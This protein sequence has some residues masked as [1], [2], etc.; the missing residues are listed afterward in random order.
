MRKCLLIL[1]LFFLIS[2]T[3]NKKKEVEPNNTR[4]E[5]QLIKLPISLTG[6][7]DHRDIDYYKFIITE[8]VTNLMDII[9]SVKAENHLVLSLYHQNTLL[10]HTYPVRNPLKEEQKKIVLK[11]IVIHPGVYYIKI[12]GMPSMSEETRYTLMIKEYTHDDT[13][14]MEPNDKLVEANFINITNGYIKGYFNPAINLVIDGDDQEADWYKFSTTGKSNVLSLEITSIPDIDPV[15]ELYNNL[16]FMIKK[17]DSM[18]L[19]EPEILKNFGLLN[20]GEY[21]IK[22]YNK[23]KN[24]QNERTPYQLYLGLKELIPQF[25]MEPNDSINKANFLKTRI[26]GYIN[27]LS[28][29]DWYE[30][31]VD[32]EKAIYNISIT[33]VNS[34]DM[35]INI[36]NSIG[37]K[38]YDLNAY[39]VNEAEIIPNLLLSHGQYFLSVSDSSNKNQNYL[40]HYTLILKKQ[41]FDNNWEYEPNDLLK[42]AIETDINR[43]IHGYISSAQD[44]DTFKFSISSQTS[45]KIDITPVPHIDPV[46]LILDQQKNIIKKIN[47]N[48]S[49]EGETDTLQ[50]SEGTYYVI[51][52]DADKKSNFYENYIFSIYER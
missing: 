50:L 21:F 19:D 46:I 15:I 2:C 20:S 34:I 33:P 24:S 4:W 38:I 48:S 35:S 9:L 22:V 10:K 51:L 8:S 6:K 49:G 36:Y 23:N 7:M 26:Q 39:S 13:M 47:S 37:E 27:P 52:S 45:I 31:T 40:D 42:Q 18:G 30:F 16:G 11:N 25:E 17:A 14:E 12:S 43:S 3:I 29:Q 5:S 1:L 32:E 28:D 44:S 41:P